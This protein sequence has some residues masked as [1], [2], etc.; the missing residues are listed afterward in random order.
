L[1]RIISADTSIHL[2]EARHFN[3]SFR[4]WADVKVS[5]ERGFRIVTF[6]SINISIDT[7]AIPHDKLEAETK[8]STGYAAG[9]WTGPQIPV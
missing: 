8:T 5:E 1:R 9:I 2:S 3:P 4:S 6:D 7:S